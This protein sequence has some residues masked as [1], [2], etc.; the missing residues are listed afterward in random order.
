MFTSRVSLFIVCVL[1]FYCILYIGFLDL[2]L[3]VLFSLY[4]LWVGLTLVAI[5]PVAPLTGSNT[6]DRYPLL[7]LW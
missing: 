6:L 2:L 4:Y 3:I 1:Y 5:A 7:R